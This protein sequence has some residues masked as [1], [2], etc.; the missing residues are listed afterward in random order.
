MPSSRGLPEVDPSRI[1][2]VGFSQGADT[3]LTI[4]ASGSAPR[5][6]IPDGPER[7][8]PRRPSIRP[9]PTVAGERLALPTLIL[10]GAADAVTPAADCERLARSSPARVRL[11]VYPGAGHCFDDPGIRRRQAAVLGMTL[12]YD[13]DAASGRGRNSAFLAE[14]ARAIGGF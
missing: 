8:A 7:S 11:V 3:A 2:A 1:A 13:A 5:F 10:V 14:E 12:N 6:A 9:A 4:A